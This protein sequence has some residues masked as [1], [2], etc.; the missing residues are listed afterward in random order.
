MKNDLE[1]NLRDLFDEKVAR[2]SLP[3][4]PPGEVV[5]RAR[6]RQAAT[7]LAAAA[8][9][10]AVVLASIA[11]FQ[12]SR[13]TKPIPA[14]THTSSATLPDGSIGYPEGWY[15]VDLDGRPSEALAFQLT[16]F[17]PGLAPV[18]CDALPPAGALLTIRSTVIEW[19]GPP[20]TWPVPLEEDDQG[21]CPG[22][23]RAEWSDG[24]RD[25]VATAAFSPDA[26]D[27]DHAALTASFESLRVAP[28]GQPFAEDLYGSPALI[29]ATTMSPAGPVALYAYEDGGSIWVSVTGP[30][31]SGISGFLVPLR[32][33]V[34][35]ANENVGPGF[36]SWGV[37]VF[38]EVSDRVARAD[39]RTVEGTAF[40]TTL[41]TLPASL[42]ADGRA[43]VLGFDDRP[44]D[45]PDVV[46]VLY[47]TAGNPLTES[48][49]TDRRTIIASGRDPAVG[50]W[51]VF[52][53]H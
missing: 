37:M 45:P 2:V 1:R 26:T 28:P 49:P 44:V 41:V 4:Q 12:A 42:G 27:D 53:N 29:V 46:I 36:F 25:F 13:H 8:A 52:L 34:P 51:S 19:A 50:R 35:A 31:G 43:M 15:V 47:D 6:R 39:A 38:G 48:Y 21:G 14:D 18:A 10:I 32:G 22:A 16:D 24:D 3:I 5:R 7:A 23:M 33:E 40:P 11:G 9:V 17:D 20:A 30:R